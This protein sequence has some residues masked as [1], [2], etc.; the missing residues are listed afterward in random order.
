VKPDFGLTAQDDGKYRAGFPESFFER[1][2]SCGVGLPGQRVARGFARQG[3][4][5][6]GIDPAGALLDEAARLDRATGVEVACREGRAEDTSLGAESADVVAAGQCWHWFDR[7][8][9]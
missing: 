5:V 2:R 3:C 8:T 1:L 7:A 9:E 6:I 4:R